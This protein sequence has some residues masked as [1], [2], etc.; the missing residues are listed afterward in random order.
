MSVSV[1]V[2]ALTT[3]TFLFT[4]VEGST[5]LLRS[6]RADYP[7]IL[8]E[9][10][11]ILRELFAEFGGKEIDNQG[12]AF[13]VAF[14]RARD[15]ILCA[16][17]CQRELARHVWPDCA[18]VRVRMGIHTGEAE[19]D[20]ERYVGLSVHRAAR[21]SGVGHGGQILVSQTTASLLEDDDE[22]PGVTL[23]DLGEHRLKDLSR[24][25]HLYQADVDG[26][27]TT[28][29]PLRVEPAP[30]LSRRRRRALVAAA[31]LVVAATAVT[32]VILRGRS[33]P[34][35]V[36]VPNSLVRLD[37]T[38]LKPTQVDPVGSSPDLVVT[39]GGYL[40][41][42]HYVLRNTGPA[43]LVNSG[44]RTL[45]RVD[46]A[47]G[48]ATVVGGGLAPCGIAPDPSGDIWVANCFASRS[49]QQP[50]LVRIDAKTLGF[51]KGPWPA[52]GGQGYYRG[53]AYGDGS[54][55]AA[56]ITG[57]AVTRVTPTGK[58]TTIRTAEP[59][60]AV[61]WSEASGDL[62][63]TNFGSGTLTQLNTATG[64]EKIVQ[65]AA[66]NPGSV[67]VDGDTVWVGDWSS[68][69]V[70][71]LR[72]IGSGSPRSISLPVRNAGTG[73]W[74]I[75]AGAGYIWATTPGYNSLWRIDPSTNHV[76]RIKLPYRPAGVAADPNNVWVTL[77]GSLVPP[78]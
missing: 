53:L 74:T 29:P 47:T 12:D 68:P 16:A 48:D 55:W 75:A 32:E 20:T 18:S 8:A 70:V 54:L 59:P 67:A 41:I 58:R 72:A 52:P 66:I 31:A 25:A 33:A 73:V 14:G 36:I 71:R 19:L 22:L 46:P 17:A 15:A 13:F 62:W 56:N 27:E 6:Y 45:T 24:P 28:F 51:V 61:A 50:N 42:T 4:D 78:A 34:P 38:T 43:G 64:A 60:G 3:A 23:R 5:Q 11:R 26:L 7:R 44:A 9:H 21:V 39:S 69:T 49:G 77:Q 65:Q 40:W 63:L 35:P 30:E 57:N 76:T 10:H 37:P 2:S 1:P